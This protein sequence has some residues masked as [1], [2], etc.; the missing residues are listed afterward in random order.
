MINH[1]LYQAEYQA[2]QLVVRPTSGLIGGLDHHQNI[3]THQVSS[4]VVEGVTLPPTY[5]VMSGVVEGVPS[6]PP[7]THHVRGEVVEDVTLPNI[8]S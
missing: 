7:P 1:W 2:S 4:G 3:G 5:Q 8:P 6:P